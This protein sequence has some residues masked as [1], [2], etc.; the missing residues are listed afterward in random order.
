MTGIP[1]LVFTCNICGRQIDSF[2]LN[3]LERETG[4][5]PHCKAHV[6]LRA[7]AYLVGKALFDQAL[8]VHQWPMRPELRGLGVSDW[9]DFAKI[10]SPKFSYVNTQFD[11]E[12]FVSGTFLDVTKPGREFIGAFEVISCSEVLEHVEPPV[13]PAFDGL[14]SMLKP[15]GSLVFTVPYGF[16]KTI[17]HFP[18]LH[19]WK[20]VP[21]GAKR[22]LINVTIDGRRQEFND[23]CFHGGGESVLEMRLFGLDDLKNRLRKAGFV[24]ICVMDEN[25]LEFGIYWPQPWSRP[26]TAK[27]PS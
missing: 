10:Y 2:T 17:E 25:V 27:R 15:G 23:L 24:N 20:L 3:D 8:P 13:Q 1:A 19:E 14:Y 18:E 11:R 7:L 22:K 9:P 5:C 16:R 12:L 26:I 21:F 4:A 6:R